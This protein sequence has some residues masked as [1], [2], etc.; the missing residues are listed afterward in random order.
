MSSKAM[1]D[2]LNAIFQKGMIEQTSA[3]HKQVESAHSPLAIDL[4]DI[5]VFPLIY[6]YLY[7]ELDMPLMTRAHTI[8]CTWIFEFEEVVAISEVEKSEEAVKQ[9]EPVEIKPKAPTKGFLKNARQ[10]VCND[11]YAASAHAYEK[12]LEIYDGNKGVGV[13]KRPES[14]ELYSNTI[15]YVHVLSVKDCFLE[16]ES[17]GFTS[18]ENYN[19]SSCSWGL[20]VNLEN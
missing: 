7:M 5:C 18:K 8:L 20:Q 17:K 3:A 4:R 6:M 14:L 12:Y 19:M 16:L 10:A 15:E 13:W 9:W 11:N 2:Q 1:F